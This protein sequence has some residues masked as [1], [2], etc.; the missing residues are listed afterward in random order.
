MTGCCNRK[1]LV[2]IEVVRSLRLYLKV[3]LQSKIEGQDLKV[4]L[5]EEGKT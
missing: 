2:F 4:A 1:I 3:V 5:T